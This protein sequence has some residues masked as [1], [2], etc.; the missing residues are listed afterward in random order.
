MRSLKLVQLVVNKNVPIG[1]IL[2]LFAY[3][4]PRFLE[5]A[6]PMS[7]LLAIIL[8]FGRLS[9]DSELVI[10]R[11][12][13]LNT[14]SLAFPVLVFS[15]A[16]CLFSLWLTFWVRPWANHQL[17]LGMFEIA[18]NQASAGLVAGTFNDL[19]QLTIYAETIS[20]NGSH[21]NNVII[22]D[23]RSLKSPKIFVARYGN[24]LSNKENRTLTLQL[25]DGTIQ[26]GT[27]QNLG[28]T[29]FQT[30]SLVLPH[31]EILG[32]VATTSGKKSSEMFIEELLEAIHTSKEKIVSINLLAP[33][34]KSEKEMILQ[35]ARYIVEL[36]T[37]LALPVSCLCIALI[38]MALGIQPSRGGHTWGATTNIAVGIFLILVYYLLFAIAVALGEQNKQPILL[39]WLPNLFYTALGLYLFEKMGSE[40]WLTVSQTLGDNLS[41][42][43]QKIRSTLGQESA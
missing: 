40:S 11:A 14:K 33:P 31:N 12:T 22:G 19:G 24:I 3:I 29:Y 25:Y 2:L 27:G 6:V 30:N 4:V 41:S 35:H 36:N 37:R 9:Q 28:V 10:I 5:I 15:L 42:I 13:G 38:A 23:R 16:T 34:S 39:V 7:L 43:F 21:L 8:A 32:D 18:K 1:E 20:T 17:G 26:E